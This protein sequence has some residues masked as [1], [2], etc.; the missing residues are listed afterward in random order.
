M[1]LVCIEVQHLRS[2]IVCSGGACSHGGQRCCMSLLPSAAF[3]L[4]PEFFCRE[5]GTCVPEK[6]KLVTQLTS[7]S[8]KD[9][10]RVVSMH[11]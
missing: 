9:L 8:L 3:S 10:H 7:D 6:M 2:A 1:E 4:T 11:M 5:S